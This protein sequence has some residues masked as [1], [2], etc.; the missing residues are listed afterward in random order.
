VFCTGKI[1]YDLTA[2]P[3]RDDV[4]VVRVEEL[5]PWPHA[6]VS[7]VLDLYPQVRDVAWV[8]EEPK[9]MGA[10]SYVAPR[11]RGSV[12][13]ALVIRYIGRVVRASPAEGHSQAHADEQARIVAEAVT[14]LSRSTGSRTPTGLMRTV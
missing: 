5:H 3:V 8:Q 10:W 7:R 12:G 4:A 11:L 13:N 14:L 9:N 6:E 2:K 1:Y